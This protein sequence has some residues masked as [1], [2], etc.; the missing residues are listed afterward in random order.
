MKPENIMLL[1]FV[2]KAAEYLEKQGFVDKIVERKDMR[3]TLIDLL[4]LHQ[5]NNQATA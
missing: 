5:K 3:N 2:D 1:G 4:K